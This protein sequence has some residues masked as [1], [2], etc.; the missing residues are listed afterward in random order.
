MRL[1]SCWRYAVAVM[2][3]AGVAVVIGVVPAQAASGGMGFNLINTLSGGSPSY[4][5]T[6]GPQ[7]VPL[8]P[9]VGN[10]TGQGATR[11]A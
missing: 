1:G 4:S 11:S 9:V 5:F 2:A 10:W 3:A 6:Y 7:G 8:S